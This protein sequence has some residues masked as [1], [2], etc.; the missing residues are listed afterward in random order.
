MQ[1]VSAKLTIIRSTRPKQLTKAFALN[2][3]GELVSRAAAN[4]IEG[5]A[6]RYSLAS[7]EALAAVSGG[8]KVGRWSGGV[9]PLRG[10]VI[11]GHWLV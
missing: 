2:D 6:S 8:A 1:A 11:T 9:V 10:G 4:M 5:T 7:L 3:Q